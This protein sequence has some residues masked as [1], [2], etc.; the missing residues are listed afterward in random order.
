LEWFLDEVMGHVR[1]QLPHV[2]LTVAGTGLG[3]S[4]AGGL[5]ARNV[6]VLGHVPDLA[7]L[8]GRARVAIAPLRFG[9]GLKGKVLEAWSYGVACAMTPVAAEGLPPHEALAGAIAGRAE[10][11]ARALVILHEDAKANAAHVAAGRALLRTQFSASAVAGQLHQ[12][13]QKEQG[14]QAVVAPLGRAARR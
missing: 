3:R 8:Y 13:V 14:G 6:E 4:L 9:A 5:R 2:P 1:A 10:D 7:P 12:A 11:Y